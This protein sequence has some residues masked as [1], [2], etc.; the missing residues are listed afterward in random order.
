VDFST[1]GCVF[2]FVGG[3]RGDVVVVVVVVVVVKS[4]GGLGL[5]EKCFDCFLFVFLTSLYI[6]FS[7]VN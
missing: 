5:Q 6:F 3:G 4:G 2:G 7:L 1:S